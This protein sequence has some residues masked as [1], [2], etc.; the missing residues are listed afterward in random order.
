[1]TR[2]RSGKVVLTPLSSTGSNPDKGNPS[3]QRFKGQITHRLIEKQNW[4]LQTSYRI[5]YYIFKDPK[6]YGFV[7]FKKTI[8][9]RI[10]H[11][12]WKLD[13][14]KTKN[15][16][17]ILSFFLL[18][19]SL[20]LFLEG[21]FGVWSFN[22]LKLSLSSLRHFIDVFSSTLQRSLT[23][24]CHAACLDVVSVSGWNQQHRVW[25]ARVKDETTDVWKTGGL[26]S[27]PGDL[28]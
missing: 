27:Y 8:S 10:Y 25:N 12:I 19:G 21:T 20:N 5:I 23:A 7:T 24:L 28:I 13:C 2:E 15:T 6:S 1:M 18:W 9:L 16:D 17:D 14:W 11:S 4:L 26:R 3:E 22:M